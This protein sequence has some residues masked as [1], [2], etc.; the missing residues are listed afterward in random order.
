MNLDA[1]Y[2]SRWDLGTEATRKHVTPVAVLLKKHTNSICVRETYKSIPMYLLIPSIIVFLIEAQKRYDPSSNLGLS[3]NYIFT[4]NTILIIQP[5]QPIHI[6]IRYQH[7]SNNP[8]FSYLFCRSVR[9]AA[10][11]HTIFILEIFDEVRCYLF[12]LIS[13]PFQYWT[14]PK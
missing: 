11:S 4:S 5:Y 2:Q 8:I 1:H 7:N 9:K 10:S 14:A 13:D 3:Q 6:S 12:G